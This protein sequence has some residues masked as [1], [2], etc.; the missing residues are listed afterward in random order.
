[1]LLRRAWPIVS[2]NLLRS[3]SVRIRSHLVRQFKVQSPNL[4]EIKATIIFW[5]FSSLMRLWHNLRAPLAEPR[6]SS[7]AW[8]VCMK[9]QTTTTTT[10]RLKNH[11]GMI[12]K[13]ETTRSLPLSSTKMESIQLHVRKNGVVPGAYRNSSPLAHV[14]LPEAF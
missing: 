14:W 10:M 13:D 4:H 3:S 7:G 6:S 2:L 5:N 8:N 11:C 1:M 9:P 12:P